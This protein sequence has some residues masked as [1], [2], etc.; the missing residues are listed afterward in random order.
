MWR[1]R[2]DVQWRCCGAQEAVLK[3]REEAMRRVEMR[4]EVLEMDGVCTRMRG[5]KAELKVVRDETGA[6]LGTFGSWEDAPDDVCDSGVVSPAHFV[7]DGDRAIESV[8]ELMYGSKD[9]HQL[10]QFHLSREYKRNIGSAG[11][12]EARALLNADSLS[13]ARELAELIMSLT[14]GRAT[15]WCAKALKQGLAHLGTGYGRHK[16]TSRLERF[17]RE[18]RCRERMGT[19]WTMHNLLALLQIRGLL[20]S[21]T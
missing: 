11:F 16:M 14:V 21:T 1:V 20:H 15:Y 13:Q 5:G 19:G 6:A 3:T 9:R 2:E 7:S 17:H 8:I 18:L 10:C 4:G 12:A